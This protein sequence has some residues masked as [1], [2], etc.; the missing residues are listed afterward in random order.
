M[1]H[2]EAGFCT[3][4]QPARKPHVP[5]SEWKGMAGKAQDMQGTMTPKLIILQTSQDP[6]IDI[7]LQ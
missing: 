3:P 2:P 5:Y 7:I 6:Q 1:P 4:L